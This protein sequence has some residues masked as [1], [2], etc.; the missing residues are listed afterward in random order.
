MSE[1]MITVPLKWYSNLLEREEWLCAL[2][3]AGVDNWEG[4]E[5]ASET[6][7]KW[8]LGRITPQQAI[9]QITNEIY[10]KPK[11]NK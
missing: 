11:E 2:E 8:T 5:H 7:D 3:C 9:S 4:C 10:L 1:E 6:L